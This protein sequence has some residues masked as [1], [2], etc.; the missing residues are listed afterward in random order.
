MT[1]NL[2]PITGIP[3]PFF[4]YG[5]SFMLACWLAVGI[6]VRI[7]AEGRGGRARWRSRSRPV[8]RVRQVARRRSGSDSLAAVPGQAG[9]IFPHGMVPE[10]EKAPRSRDASASRSRPTP[11]RNARRAGTRTSARS[12]C[13]TSTSARTATITAASARSSTCNLLLDDGTIEETELDIRS[14][15]PLGFPEYP[16]APEEGARERGRR[17]RHPDGHRHARR[18]CR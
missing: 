5:G 11:G 7:S 9:H 15:D 18:D 4:S 16:G 13:G 10:G 3:L 8:E 1:L 6:C 12:S 14:T 2:M 17:R